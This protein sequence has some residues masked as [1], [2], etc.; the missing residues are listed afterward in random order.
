M[1]YRL[2]FALWP[3]AATQMRLEQFLQSITLPP[4]AQ[5]VHPQDLHMTLSFIGACTQEQLQALSQQITNWQLPPT[6]FHLQFDKLVYW[7]RARVLVA[8]PANVPES[9]L[10]LV[11]NL[12]K[13]IADAGLK[14]D[15]REYQPHVTLVHRLD[16]TAALPIG[17]I[18]KPLH[19]TSS[20]FYLANSKSHPKPN[21]ARYQLLVH[22][23]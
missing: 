16:D 14:V 6:S 19:F 10:V 2:F 8:M 17:A 4:E 21:R 15:A 23:P 11:D 20:G 18:K 5:A 9:L 3:D 12:N 13:L 1:P 22:Q 7:H